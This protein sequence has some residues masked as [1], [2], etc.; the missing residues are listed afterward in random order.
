MVA[1][2]R[3]GSL[4]VLAVASEDADTP[5][6]CLLALWD[7]ASTRHLAQVDMAADFGVATVAEDSV[8]DI[9]V[10]ASVGL[11]EVSVTKAAV[12]LVDSPPRTPLLDLVVDEVDMVEA[13]TSVVLLAA[14]GSPCDPA[15]PTRIVAM[16]ATAMVTATEIVTACMTAVETAIVTVTVTVMATGMA[17]ARTMDVSDTVRTML[18]TTTPAPGDGTKCFMA[19]SLSWTLLPFLPLFSWAAGGYPYLFFTQPLPTSG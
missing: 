3:D 18:P 2:P 1:Q 17:A 19:L 4:V 7:L 16:T 9:A 11:V 10:I 14:T 12:V 5:R 8:E 15:M 6:Q 13:D